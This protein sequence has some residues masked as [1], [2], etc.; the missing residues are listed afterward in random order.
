M[1]SRWL[2]FYHWEESFEQACAIFT[3][4]CFFLA[5]ECLP[6]PLSDTKQTDSVLHERDQFYIQ[7]VWCLS[8][9]SEGKTGP[10]FNMGLPEYEHI[11]SLTKVLQ[12]QMVKEQTKQM[13]NGRWNLHSIFLTPNVMCLRNRHINL[14]PVKPMPNYPALS[15]GA[16]KLLSRYRRTY[17]P[18]IY[19]NYFLA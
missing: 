18:Q 12:Q 9:M 7:G 14:L 4:G 3:F 5:D 11:H 2:V 6:L 19:A 17:R 13:Q 16:C 1:P 8:I 10:A 15:V